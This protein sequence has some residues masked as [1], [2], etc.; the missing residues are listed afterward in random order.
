ML[1]CIEKDERLFGYQKGEV[2]LYNDGYTEF[3]EKED[4]IHRLLQLKDKNLAKEM[5]DAL[6]TY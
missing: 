1:A 2:L 4:G 5:L 6:L 3:M